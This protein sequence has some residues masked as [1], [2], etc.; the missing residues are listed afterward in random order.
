M[1]LLMKNILQ[2]ISI[3]ICFLLLGN[4]IVH[5]QTQKALLIGISKYQSYKPNAEWSDINGTN[6][7]HLIADDLKNQG[8]EQITQLLDE[9]ATCKTIID[10]L[11]K[12][13]QSASKG[14][15]IYFHFSGH[16]QPV[17]DLNGDEGHADGWDEAII[18]YDAG[19]IFQKDEYE[20]ENHIIDDQL[21]KF[22]F[23]LR[24]RVGETGMVYA[25]IDACY[26]GT[27][28]R[29]DDEDDEEIDEDAPLRGVNVG[30]DY[31]EFKIY[32]PIVN[33]SSYYQL[34]KEK[35]YSDIVVL[36]ACLPHQQNREI[37]IND[38]YY[39]PLSY[40]IHE[41]IK[42]KMITKQ[43]SWIGDVIHLFNADKRTFRQKIVCEST[44]DNGK[45]Y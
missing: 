19:M 41:I 21:E 25:V 17:L 2:L 14:D 39:G 42:N 18:P 23:K 3:F 45:G 33:R 11:K 29:G 22:I 35:N 1:S 30:F 5:G 15:I 43:T 13:T 31:G 27:G 7:I 20:G 36:E 9:Q 26:S 32:S 38:S 16:G 44:I 37:K 10:E 24:K 28:L 34:P 40:Y 12:L 4:S 6:D 8:F